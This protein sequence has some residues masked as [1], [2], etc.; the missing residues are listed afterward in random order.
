MAKK[1]KLSAIHPGEILYE[2]Y[3]VPN[4]LNARKLALALH[5]DAPRINDIIRGRRGVTADTALR[6]SAFFTGTT[7][8]FWLGLQTNYD[9]RVAREKLGQRARQIRALAG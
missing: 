1:R 5:T 8:G 3:M 4:G 7:P 6:L 2:E 9:V